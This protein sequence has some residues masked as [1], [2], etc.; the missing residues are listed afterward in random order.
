MAYDRYDTREGPRS[1][2]GRWRDDRFGRDDERGFFER[3]GDEIAS[4]FGDDD[5]ERRR[6]EDQPQ[7]E[8]ERGWD[9]FGSRGD[10]DRDRDPRRERAGARLPRIWPSRP[11]LRR[12]RL[13]PRRLRPRGFRT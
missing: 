3:A 13:C 4:W 7:M 11:V 9:R 6:R 2:R 5:A 10:F 1:E 8:R 12:K